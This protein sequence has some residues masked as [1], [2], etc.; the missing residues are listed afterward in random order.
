MILYAEYTRLHPERSIDSL[1]ANLADVTNKNLSQAVDEIGKPV[2]WWTGLLRKF[3][4][5]KEPAT[6]TSPKRERTLERMPSRRRAAAKSRGDTNT[7]KAQLASAGL[8]S[9][10]NEDAQIQLLLQVGVTFPHLHPPLTFSHPSLTVS[11]PFFGSSHLL[12]IHEDIQ[13]L[14]E[15]REASRTAAEIAAASC[16]RSNSLPAAR[17]SREIRP[18]G[19]S[20]EISAPITS[21]RRGADAPPDASVPR[22][23]T[24]WSEAL[25]DAQAD[26]LAE[27]D[28]L[29]DV[30]ISRDRTAD[31]RAPANDRAARKSVEM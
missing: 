1:S 25:A 14:K 9:D 5:L 28:H 3:I 16:S 17:T 26:A 31:E 24:N 12:Q 10:A 15:Q 21:G 8:F 11:H 19:M 13:E 2:S 7:T 22:A 29:H 20:R 4:G 6:R 30:Q 27:N 18:G 23:R